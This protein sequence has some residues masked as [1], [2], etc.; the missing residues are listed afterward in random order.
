SLIRSDS[1]NCTDKVDQWLLSTTP[2][3]SAPILIT[4]DNDFQPTDNNDEGENLHKATT[5]SVFND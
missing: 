4:A 1:F 3:S 2:M 5:I